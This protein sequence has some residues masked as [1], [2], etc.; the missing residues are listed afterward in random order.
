MPRRIGSA[1][2]LLLTELSGG[3]RSIYTLSGENVGEEGCRKKQ[4]EE[5]V[6]RSKPEMVETHSGRCVGS[7]A[8]KMNIVLFIL[9]GRA[10]AVE[11]Q[12]YASNCERLGADAWTQICRSKSIHSSNQN[13]HTRVALRLFPDSSWRQLSLL[14][15]SLLLCRLLDIVL[16]RLSSN[17]SR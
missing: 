7:W 4:E 12:L 6:L 8:K 11:V 3:S 13:L 10:V 5:L 14:A 17:E 16:L 9:G 2:S 1:S 15:P